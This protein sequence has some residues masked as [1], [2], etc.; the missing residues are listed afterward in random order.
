M[1]QEDTIREYAVNQ[2]IL[3]DIGNYLHGLD[4]TIGQA[5]V[6]EGYEIEEL[7]PLVEDLYKTEKHRFKEDFKHWQSK[8]HQ[9][10]YLEW[11]NNAEHSDPVMME[12]LE[13]YHDAISNQVA[14]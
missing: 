9:A 3:K 7:R 12:V 13:I 6:E 1:N 5:I 10:R 4:S 11:I 8:E 14:A 2:Y